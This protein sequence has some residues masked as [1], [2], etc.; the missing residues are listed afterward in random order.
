MSI[1]QKVFE[2]LSGAAGV[3]ALCP[4]SRIRPDGVYQGLAR[5]YIKHFPVALERLQTHQGAAELTRWPYQISMFADS[6]E[7]LAGLRAAVMAALEASADPRF[8]LTGLERLEGSDE[9]ELP[10]VG[11]ALLLDAW[12]Q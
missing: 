6:V 8:F 2:V 9:P 12:Y 3:V 11:E 7:S 10:I 1:E 5:P 4:A